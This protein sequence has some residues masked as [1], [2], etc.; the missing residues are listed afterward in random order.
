MHVQGIHLSGEVNLWSYIKH[1]NFARMW[2]SKVCFHKAF[3]SCSSK[4][5]SL[6][7]TRHICIS[8]HL[9]Y[10]M[11][12]NA[13]SCCYF[14]DRNNKI[15]I[16]QFSVFKKVCFR[17][18]HIAKVNIKKTFYV[19]CLRGAQRILK[20]NTHPSHSLLTLLP[21]G[22]SYRSICCRTTRLHSFIPQAASLLNSSSARQHK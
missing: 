17:M 11:N 13:F 4:L 14:V 1:S 22:K 3:I 10:R 6:K 2:R 20:N 16:Q 5:L 12:T 19:W 9:C 15:Q 21:S 8:K 18:L 7:S